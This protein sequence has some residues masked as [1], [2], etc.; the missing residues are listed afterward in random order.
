MIAFIGF[1]LSLL[2]FLL[3][4]YVDSKAITL[5]LR[6]RMRR[7]MTSAFQILTSPLRIISE[8]R[9]PNQGKELASKAGSRQASKEDGEL[10]GKDTS[11]SRMPDAAAVTSSSIPAVVVRKRISALRFYDVGDEGRTMF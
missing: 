6:T 11:A 7:A 3:E 5:R 4:I 8:L 2:V 1:A 9:K 10:E